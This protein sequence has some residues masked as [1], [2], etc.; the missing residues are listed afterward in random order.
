MSNTWK[1]KDLVFPQ[2]DLQSF[3]D[4]NKD[5]IKRIEEATDGNDVL[6]IIFEHS[7]LSRRYKDLLEITFIRQSMDTTDEEVQKQRRWV[8]E[9]TPFFDKATV[10]FNEAVYNSPF[11]NFIEEKLGPMFFVKMDLEKKVFCEDNIP[12][13]QKESELADEYQRIMASYQVEIEGE[14]RNFLTLQKLFA[15]EDREVRKKAF[16]YF[17]DFMAKNEKRLEEIWDEL[18]KIRTQ[19]ANNLGYENY[20][21]VAYFKRG[22]LDY[23]QEEVAN[24]RKQVLEEIVPF[25][26]KLYEA[27]RKRLGLDQIMAYDEGI[28][29]PDGN[30]KP[31]GDKDYM[32]ATMIDMMDDLSPETSEFINFM[33]EHE[34]MDCDE[35]PGKAAREY[36]TMIISKK[37]PFI[38]SF[39]DGSAKALKNLVGE[40]GHSFATYRSSRK[41]PIDSYYYSSADIME[42]HVMSMT[43]FSN[44]YAED[45][46]EDDAD[47]YQ[48]FNLQ[49]LMTFIPFGTAVDEFQHICYQHPELTP[50]ER[51]MEWHKLEEKYM[52]WRKYDDEDEFM[53]RGGYW[54]H[55][56][57][58]F[59]YPLYYIEYCFA[60]V[61]SM[62][63]YKKY[64]AR[65]GTA[66]QEYLDLADMGGSKSYSQTLALANLTPPYKDGAVAKAISYVKGVLEGLL[67]S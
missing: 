65:P 35:R 61:N 7:E 54:Y 25:C 64:I 3:E 40:L 53:K 26:N 41:Q 5:Y 10:D 20:L 17:S 28:M 67:K 39:F 33:V 15:H 36:S 48:F 11:R 22:R 14:T 16:G 6:E 1:F 37:A 42:I 60:T 52:P 66:W 56:P 30:A 31:A 12:L 43:Q 49:D 58:I 34:L 8:Y 21:P 62:E 45:F 38:F 2:P 51:N 50:E 4:M 32:M 27:Q 23:G 55:K 44:R 57:H 59:L 18:I 9:H 19:I 46:F 47:K 13:N 63:M 29:F 24:F